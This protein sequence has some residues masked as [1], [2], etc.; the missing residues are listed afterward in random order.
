MVSLKWP[1][2]KY[3]A[4]LQIDAD[5]TYAKK[6]ITEADARLNEKAIAAK[7]LADESYNAAVQKASSAFISKKYEEALTAYLIAQKWKPDDEYVKSQV[8]LINKRLEEEKLAD[9]NRKKD[10][11]FNSYIS[12]ADKSVNDGA[13]EAA[14]N[15]Y[16]EA[17][18]VKPNDAAAL[19]KLNNAKEI[20]TAFEQKEQNAKT[21]LLYRSYINTADKAYLDK[22]YE[23]AKLAYMKALSTKENDKYSLDQLKKI[24][25]DQQSIEEEKITKQKAIAVE[26]QYNAII[27]FAD[28]T[29]NM[30]LWASS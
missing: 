29:F 11:L 24:N 18:I 2:E 1:K 22:M 28:S 27:R 7:R 21:E 8:E 16:N 13:Y 5:N 26:E 30:Q 17:L 14:I 15:S 9:T 6:Q 25:T 3:K 10:S 23:E 20:K 12:V 4:V 19:M